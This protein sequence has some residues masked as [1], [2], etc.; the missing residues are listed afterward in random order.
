MPFSQTFS[1]SKV[2]D[3]H[4]FWDVSRQSSL[5][6]LSAQRFWYNCENEKCFTFANHFSLHNYGFLTFLFILLGFIHGHNSQTIWVRELKQIAIRFSWC[7][8]KVC[9]FSW[10]SKMVSVIF[11]KFLMVIWHGFTLMHYNMLYI[12]TCQ[13]CWGL[14]LYMSSIFPITILI[15]TV[16]SWGKTVLA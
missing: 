4:H 16:F 1:Q 11:L 6:V 3:F 14:H 9:Q 15:G 13:E 12:N 8:L 5:N 2:L 10:K 7:D